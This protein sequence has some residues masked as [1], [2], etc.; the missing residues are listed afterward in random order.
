MSTDLYILGGF[1]EF[2][3]DD[4]SSP[5]YTYLYNNMQTF[6]YTTTINNKEFV[7]YKAGIPG[8]ERVFARDTIMS[9]LL[10]ENTSMMRHILDICKELQGTKFDAFTG[11]E[12][13]KMFHEYIGVDLNGKNTL[14]A[15]CD[16][17]ALYLIGL[18]WYAQKTEDKMIIK[19]SIDTI[20]AAVK[21]IESHVEN[22]I[23]WEKPPISNSDHLALKVT[24]WKD[25]SLQDREGGNPDFPVCFTLA[26]FQNLAGI[27]AAAQ[28]L[29]DEKLHPLI[30]S[31]VEGI[32]SLFHQ[33]KNQ[34]CVARDSQGDVFGISDDFL[35]GLY[36]LEP[37]DLNHDEKAFIHSTS[38]ALETD[39]GI[40]TNTSDKCDLNDRY[41][42]CTLWPF[43]Q[44]F[45]HSGAKKFGFN[46]LQYICERSVRLLDSYPEFSYIDSEGIEAQ[47]AGNDP[48][49]WTWAV[50]KYF[51]KQ[52]VDV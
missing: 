15:A 10:S 48:Q 6:R 47:K 49:L 8:Y 21:Y 2:L 30:G 43:E 31:M 42:T 44:G 34:F 7:A 51:K 27:R 9:A 12:P 52:G 39:F 14:Y 13:G 41:H 16:T 46:D 45:I 35:H 24:Y 32:H 18:A 3:V 23:F 19:N 28:M 26:H 22:S 5:R 33:E 29:N 25:S 20:R 36:Y 37:T 40:R 17:T 1:S 50:K 4:R 38:I 11:E